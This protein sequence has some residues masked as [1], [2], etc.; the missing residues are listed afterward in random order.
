MSPFARGQ[1]LGGL[2]ASF[3]F[4]IGCSSASGMLDPRSPVAAQIADLWWLLL[5]V[6][7]LVFAP[8][9]G[10]LL[11][12][13]FHARPD[14]LS[15]PD[16][17]LEERL[18]V[19]GG[20]V[21]PILVLSFVF[22]LTVQNTLA[23]SQAPTDALTIRVTGHRW[24]WQ[25]NYPAAG[26]E[27]ANEIHIPTG[28]PVRVELVTADVI[29]SFWVPQLAGKVD[30]MPNKTNELWLHAAEA[31][32]FSGYCAEFCGLQHA[33]MKFRIRAMPPD[34]FDA[35]LRAQQQLAQPPNDAVAQRGLQVFMT[36]ECS[37]CHTIRGTDAA[38][39]KG[40]DL[41]H[42]AARET[43][44]AGTLKNT[45]EELARWIRDPE[46]IKRG[47]AMEATALSDS[48]LNALLDYLESLQ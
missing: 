43:L 10:L 44:A 9:L 42:L 32:T 7:L 5:V 18:V 31:G 22:V 48:D 20:L 36:N 3:V 13:L 37:D 23:L 1:S 14:D 4:L 33:M 2:L 12:A 30:L 47:T 16:K 26:F 40:P 19:G 11:Y 28:T 6:A 17:K 41:T 8:V 38:G 24:W 27:T 35:W 29:H 15:T 34:E 25:V 46:K 21:M 39:Q 45:R